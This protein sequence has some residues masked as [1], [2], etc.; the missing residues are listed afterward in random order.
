MMKQLELLFVLFLLVEE[1]RV[2]RLT[3]GILREFVPCYDR[4]LMEFLCLLDVFEVGFELLL[5][6][7]Q[8]VQTLEEVLS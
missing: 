1:T 2:D 8:L 3:F 6:A 7:S 4:L 5:G